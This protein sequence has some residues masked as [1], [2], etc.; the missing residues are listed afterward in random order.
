MRARAA[1]LP[2]RDRRR[3]A[4]HRRRLPRSACSLVARME[5]RFLRSPRTVAVTGPYRFYDWDWAGVARGARVRL[6]ARAARARHGAPR[7]PDRGDSLRRQLR[8]AARRR[9]TPSAASTPPLSSTGKTPTWG[10]A[11]PRSAP[12]SSPAAA[13]STRRRGATWRSDAEGVPPVRPQLLVGDDPPSAQGSR[14]RGRQTLRCR[15]TSLFSCA[16]FTRIPPGA[17]GG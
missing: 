8:G 15:D 2:G 12:S 13:T 4:V 11:S 14:P 7:A 16:I 5:R 17:T 10:A 6:H 3:A 1:G 9:S